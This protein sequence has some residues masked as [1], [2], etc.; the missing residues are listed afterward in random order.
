MRLRSTKRAGTS[1]LEYVTFF[2]LIVFVV[3]A[4][5]PTVRSWVVNNLFH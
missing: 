4:L 5:S 1:L 2:F 3:F